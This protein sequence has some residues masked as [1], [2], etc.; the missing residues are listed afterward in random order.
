M[1]ACPFPNNIK[2]SFNESYIS[3][4]KY[5]NKKIAAI[6]SD[7]TIKCVVGHVSNTYQTNNYINRNLRLLDGT[8]GNF[9]DFKHDDI[10]GDIYSFTYNNIN[11]TI[12]I[13]GILAFIDVL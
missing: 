9:T 4:Y 12:N 8:I 2:L 11:Y 6:Y 13:I 3:A 5:S 1:M 7:Q 10:W